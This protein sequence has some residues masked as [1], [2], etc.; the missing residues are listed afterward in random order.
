MAKPKLLLLDEPSWAWHPCYWKY[1]ENVKEINAQGPR[2]VGRTKHQVGTCHR[3]SRLRA[4][5]RVVNPERDI[6]RTSQQRN[7]A[8]NYLELHSFLM[9]Y[10]KTLEKFRA[11]LFNHIDIVFQSRLT[12]P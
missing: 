10:E 5:D 2:A 9:L 3:R 6:R 7:G 1:F 4:A 8:K 12:L 11:F